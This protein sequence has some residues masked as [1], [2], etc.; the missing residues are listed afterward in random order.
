MLLATLLS[1]VGLAVGSGAVPALASGQICAQAGSGYCLNSW[2]NQ[3]IGGSIKMG[4]NGWPNQGFH[5]VH[6]TGACG[7]GFVTSSCPN[8]T[9]GTFL[10]GEPIEEI[11]FDGSTGGCVG[12]GNAD[13]RAFLVVCPD[14]NGNGGGWG[15]IWIQDGTCGT[16]AVLLANSHFTGNDGSV[17]KL[18]SGGAVGAQALVDSTTGSCWGTG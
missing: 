8:A 3:G 1:A 6:L 13:D 5:T 11:K 9:A 7:G 15:S 18:I 2:N 14:N 17:R 10:F 16:G 12:S 4:Q